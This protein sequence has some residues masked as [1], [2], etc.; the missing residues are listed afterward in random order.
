M[1]WFRLFTPPEWADWS[2]RDRLA[3]VVS[4]TALLGL[5]ALGAWKLRDL[6]A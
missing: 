5:L 4:L 2:A 3:Y 6:I 1:G